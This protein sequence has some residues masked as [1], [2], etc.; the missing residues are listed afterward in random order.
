MID[1]DA[2]TAIARTHVAKLQLASGD[3]AVLAEERTQELRGLW[4]FRW[5]SRQYLATGQ[6]GKQVI[7]N[8]AILVDQRDGTV[9]QCGTARPL[10]KY[11]DLYERSRAP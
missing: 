5:N 3:A 4:V 7:G 10:D 1:R 11:I 6:A 9:F 2:A 8:G